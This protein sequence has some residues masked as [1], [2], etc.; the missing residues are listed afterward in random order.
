MV[1]DGND[2]RGIDVGIMTK[3]T[4]NIKLIGTHVDD[5]DADGQIFSRD[6][7]EY[8]IITPS[9]N[10]LLL[11][12][13]HFKSKGY[14]KPATNDAK[15]KRQAKKVR[16]IYEERLTQGLEHIAIVGDLNDSPERDPLKPLIGD[17]ST[18]V[19]VMS[20]P[21]FKS[22]GLPGTYGNGKAKDK[23]DY[24][25]MSPKLLTKGTARRNRAAWSLGR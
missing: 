3:P 21:H 14:G 4:F 18:L 25:L 23:F 9:G 11:L 13:N 17:G 7:A 22:D 1:I 2:D 12:V 15:R 24:I 20:D 5:K 10:R 19:D 16:E 6:C 8:T